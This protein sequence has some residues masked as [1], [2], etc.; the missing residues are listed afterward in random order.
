MRRDFAPG[1]PTR[2][3]RRAS[4]F[5]LAEV[6]ISIAVTGLAFAGILASYVQSARQAEWSGYSLAAESFAV[7]Q[8]EQARSAVW[9]TSLGKN[10]L[11]DLNLI[12]LQYNSGTKTATGY[13][14]GVLDLPYS[15]NNVI[16]ATNYVTIK[17]FYFNK[18]ANPPVELQ[19]VQVDTVWPLATAK[20]TKYYTNTAATY[21]APD[22]RDPGSL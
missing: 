19:M 13:S 22:N 15:G 1:Y 6:V 5:T 14:Q 16:R 10:E 9:D 8:L 17:R 7:Q 20:G 3:G 18:A 4:G 12:N 21:F 2:R 11:L